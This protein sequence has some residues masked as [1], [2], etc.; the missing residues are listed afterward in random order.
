MEFIEDCAKTHD[1]AIKICRVAVSNL[2]ERAGAWNSRL[3]PVKD[4]VL[5]KIVLSE[6][7]SSKWEPAIIPSAPPAKEEP[8]CRP[9]KSVV[10]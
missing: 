1:I 6:G 8:E 4:D 3:D 2:L 5:M 9:L 7:W 10:S